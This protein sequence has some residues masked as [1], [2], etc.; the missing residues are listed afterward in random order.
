[1]KIIPV[2]HITN[3]DGTTSNTPDCNGAW[4]PQGAVRIISDAEN[5]TVYEDGDDIPPDPPPASSNKP[6]LDQI[7]E[8]ESSLTLRRIREAAK[9]P[10]WMNA[11]DG[12][13]AALRV[14]LSKTT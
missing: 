12:R 2:K 8:L 3:D 14:Q 4:P 10:S 7:A 1:M 6:I 11:L 9:D 13:I 5:Y